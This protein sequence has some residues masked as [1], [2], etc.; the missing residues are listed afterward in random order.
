MLPEMSKDELLVSF[1]EFP[2]VFPTSCKEHDDVPWP[3]IVRMIR[4]VPTYIDKKHCP[5]LSL[6]QYGNNPSDNDCIRH[7][8]NVKVIYGLEVDY[9]LE[10]LSIVDASRLLQEAGIR[11]VLYT[12]PSHKQTN[13]R[14]R[15]L[16]PLSEPEIPEKRAFYVGRI[17][18]ILGGVASRESFTLS[19]SFYFGRV[20]DVEYEVLETHGRCVD[21]ASEIEPL[22]YANHAPN[23]QHIRDLTTDAEL[24]A[25]F[26]R[27]ENRYTAMLKLSSRWAARGQG[28]D[29]IDAN[30]R[31][32]LGHNTLNAD[33]IDL[34]DR[35]RAT[36]ES[37]VKKYGD[38]RAV[39]K[40]EPS[41]APTPA[42]SPE[43]APVSLADFYAYMPTHAY[44]FTPTREPWPAA[45][46]NA[47]V[48]MWEVPGYISASEDNLKPHQ[49]LDS[50][51][52][53]DQ[54]TWAP[55]LPMVIRD[56]LIQGGGWFPKAGSDC[57]NLYIPPLPIPGDPDKAGEWVAH[58]QKIYPQDAAH[59]INWLAHR[60]QK[61]EEKINHALVLGGSQG[62]GKDTLLEP[63]KH[64]VGPWNVMEVS[65]TQMM[66]RFNGFVKSVILR[67]S[68]A[69]DMG[70][71][72]LDRYSFY[73]HMKTYTAAPPDVLR[74][75]EKHLREHN[76]VNV[77]GVIITTNHKADGIFLPPDD[78][79]HYVAWSEKTKEEFEQKYWDDLYGWLNSGGIGHV[80]AFLQTLD[81]SQFNAKKPP[82]KTA[83]FYEIVNSNR[84]SEEAELADAV[85]ALGHPNALTVDDVIRQSMDEMREWLKD[86]KNSKKISH[87]LESV[88]YVVVR[89]E[90]AKDGLWKIFGRRQT[91]Y[92]KNSLS[93]RER[94]GAAAELGQR[95]GSGF[96]Q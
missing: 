47:R 86:R 51:Q 69:R 75:D 5:L 1:T 45:S 78:R 36:A 25:A 56:R 43:A 18:K 12:S 96:G 41:Q 95:P 55:G 10:K 73:E 14:W 57:F 34:L 62:I 90:D 40:Y 77:C 59:I 4:E 50:N 42:K 20:K 68:E 30:L 29:D 26:D 64:A 60:V 17:N 46:V 13:P 24:R 76:I 48:P 65:P 31:E 32:L 85:E 58:V 82:P 7:A 89:N 27:G 15:V 35:V 52:A 3:D 81:L 84:P 61:P 19:Q 8:G 80:C 94:I 37:A 79:R 22:Y 70:E 93:V 87:R 83:A 6:A 38:T 16:V 63:V 66:G 92:S 33:G 2:N 54:M 39:V 72:G 23:G 67:V 88:G 21:M 49:W 28:V 74:C 44:L 53:V 9:D 71:G 91:I 11:A